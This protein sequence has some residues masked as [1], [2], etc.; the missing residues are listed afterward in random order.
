MSATREHRNAGMVD[1]A[2]T[3]IGVAITVA[4]NTLGILSGN[5]PDGSDGGHD[6]EGEAL[7]HVA[8]LRAA[9]EN[10]TEAIGL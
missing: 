7:A 10:L 2:I 6:Y 9:H 5:L 4:E 3:A 1:D 8:N